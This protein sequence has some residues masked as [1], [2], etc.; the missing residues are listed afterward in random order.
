M[1]AFP[2]W[3][4]DSYFQDYYLVPG[5]Q[6][7]KLQKD[8]NVQKLILQVH[9]CKYEEV[10][11]LFEEGRFIWTWHLASEITSENGSGVNEE[12][13]LQSFG[14]F[15]TFNLQIINYYAQYIF[16][17]EYYFALYCWCSINYNG[18]SL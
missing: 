13:F 16:N 18:P 3:F 5:Q 1:Y 7:K 15:E 11:G 4:C 17:F 6:G 10:E 12:P 2:V 14:F 9:Y 8:E